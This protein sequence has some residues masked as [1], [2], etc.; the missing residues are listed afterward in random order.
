MFYEELIDSFEARD[1]SGNV[2]EVQ[3]FQKFKEHTNKGG[4]HQVPISFRAETSTGIRLSPVG[5]DTVFDGETFN[6]GEFEID[7]TGE[8]LRKI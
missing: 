3:I 4:T 7:E 2:H 6:Y 5:E 8:R 1:K